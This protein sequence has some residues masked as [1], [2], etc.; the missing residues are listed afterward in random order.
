MALKPIQAALRKWG[1]EEWGTRSVKPSVQSTLLFQRFNL[2]ELKLYD[3]DKF[4]FTKTR[5]LFP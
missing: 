4:F 5:K 2:F 1:Q 3:V